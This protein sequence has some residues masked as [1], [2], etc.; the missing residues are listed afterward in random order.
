MHTHVRPNTW[1][2]AN[3]TSVK[4]LSKA[5]ITQCCDDHG[6]EISAQRV[7]QQKNTSPEKVIPP[8][9][10][11]VIFCGSASVHCRFSFL[12][13][14][15]I[16]GTFSLKSGDKNRS[17]IWLSDTVT[18]THTHLLLYCSIYSQTTTVTFRLCIPVIYCFNVST[19]STTFQ[20]Q[21]HIGGNVT[22]TG[23][24]HL[25]RKRK[26][27]SVS[28]VSALCF[29]WI[30]PT[31]TSLLRINLM[32]YSLNPTHDYFPTT[33]SFLRQRTEYSQVCLRGISAVFSQRPASKIWW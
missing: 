11:S 19:L 22:A 17:L 26:C 21:M 32:L 27:W 6:W 14:L 5:K 15:L 13:L 33:K 24:H 10:F 25:D 1:D 7:N 23:L 18:H 2:V 3:W 29:G 12:F 8:F 9:F 31:E 4:S 20:Q 30:P 28:D 16:T